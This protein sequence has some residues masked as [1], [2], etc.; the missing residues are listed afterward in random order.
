MTDTHY[1][2][3]WWDGTRYAEGGAPRTYT[4]IPAAL[5]AIPSDF[6]ARVV[7]VTSR[8]QKVVR[9]V[10]VPPNGV[11]RRPSKEAL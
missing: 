10:N 2:I 8:G 4:S 11:R 9:Y 7:E 3:A 5:R 1:V 6:H